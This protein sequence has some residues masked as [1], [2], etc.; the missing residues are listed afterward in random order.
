MTVRV[1]AK[2]AATCFNQFESTNFHN[3]VGAFDSQ[4]LP[5][6]KELVNRLGLGTVRNVVRQLPRNMASV[7]QRE[8]TQAQAVSIAHKD[9]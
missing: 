3:I 9:L 1:S 5:A 8:A 7:K 2:R 6:L 4:A